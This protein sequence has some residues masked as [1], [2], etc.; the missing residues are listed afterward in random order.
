[1]RNRYKLKSRPQGNASQTV[2]EQAVKVGVV[3]DRGTRTVPQRSEGQQ[4]IS[5]MA[6]V[7][8][9]IIYVQPRKRSERYDR[10]NVYR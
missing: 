8:K 7:P 2:V 10:Q 4:T 5:R 9:P 3:E 6:Y 1:M